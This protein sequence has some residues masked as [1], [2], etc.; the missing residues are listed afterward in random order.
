[1]VHMRITFYPNLKDALETLKENEYLYTHSWLNTLKIRYKYNKKSGEY[2]PV[3]VIKKPQKLFKYERYEHFIFRKEVV[4]DLVEG[5]ISAVENN[6][7]VF[8]PPLKEAITLGLKE[9]YTKTKDKN[10]ICVGSAEPLYPRGYIAQKLDNLNEPILMS[11][12]DEEWKKGFLSIST[13]GEKVEEEITKRIMKI[14]GVNP[15]RDYHNWGEYRLIDVLN[16][17]DKQLFNGKG[18]VLAKFW[19]NDGVLGVNKL[20]NT[21][22]SEWESESVSELKSMIQ[23]NIEKFGLDY[24][25]KNLSNMVLG[26]ICLYL[27]GIPRPKKAEI[28]LIPIKIAD[29]SEKGDKEIEFLVL[30]RMK[31]LSKV[32]SWMPVEVD[33]DDSKFRSSEAIKRG[34]R[35]LISLVDREKMPVELSKEKGKAILINTNLTEEVMVFIVPRNQNNKGGSPVEK[36]RH[37]SEMRDY[38]FVRVGIEDGETLSVEDYKEIKGTKIV[39]EEMAVELKLEG[40]EKELGCSKETVDMIIKKEVDNLTKELNEQKRK[41]KDPENKS[42]IRLAEIAVKRLLRTL[43]EGKIGKRECMIVGRDTYQNQNI[44]QHKIYPKVVLDGE[45]LLIKATKEFPAPEVAKRAK[46]MIESLEVEKEKKLCFKAGNLEKKIDVVEGID[47]MLKETFILYI[48]SISGTLSKMLENSKFN[49]EFNIE[50]VSGKLKEINKLSIKLSGIVA[51]AIGRLPNDNEKIN[52]MTKE[53]YK[54]LFRLM[55]GGEVEY[56]DYGE[57]FGWKGKSDTLLEWKALV[58]EMV[59]ARIRV[60]MFETVRVD[61]IYREEGRATV[62]VKRWMTTS[63][64]KDYGEELWSVYLDSGYRGKLIEMTVVR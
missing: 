33:Y 64:R 6:S 62:K 15:E 18:R 53:I 61:L 28:V 48:K 40:K 35:K 5:L 14:E 52:E 21:L 12:K 59:G 44:Y 56:Y 43:E 49:I 45:E 47:E 20:A 37:K 36:V 2:E 8:K 34:T 54:L 32:F 38:K 63:T 31:I 3:S 25:K 57:I 11:M 4:E 60:N 29:E 1:M 27:S 41:E 10:F 30:T 24:A 9:F 51:S 42:S 22:L 50:R 7:D 26:G 19:E 55:A 39:N 58:K 16:L 46:K 23:D 13:V 17:V